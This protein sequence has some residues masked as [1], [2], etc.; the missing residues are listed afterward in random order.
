M[1]NRTKETKERIGNVIKTIK[2]LE[3]V[4]IIVLF[5]ANVASAGIPISDGFDYPV[6]IPDHTGYQISGWNFLDNEGPIY[7]NV[8]HPG[9][10]WNGNGGSD[11]DL[12]DSVYAISNGH[13]VASDD[14][15]CGWG[16]ITLIEHKLQNGTIVWSNYAHLETRLVSSG[17][18]VRRGEQIGT[19]GKGA[20]SDEPCVK[21]YPAHLHF[22]TRRNY[23][24]PSSWTP[25]VD[26][27]VQVRANYYNPSDFINANRPQIAPLVGD[28]D[29]NGIDET[30]T[31][32][33]RE[34]RFI[35]RDGKYKEILNKQMGDPGDLPIVGNWSGKNA[36]IGIYRPKE[37]KFFL[38]HNNDGIIDPVSDQEFLFGNIGDY[39]IVGDWDNDGKDEIGVYR[40]SEEDATKAT[41]FLNK[42][43]K[44]EEVKFDVTANDTPIIGD[45]NNDGTDDVGVFRRFDP[46]NSKNAVF[47]LKNGT[48]MI[49]I[50]FGDNTDF[51]LAG[52][53]KKDGLTR[54]GIYRPTTEK[55]EFRSKPVVPKSS[56]KPSLD[57]DYPSGGETWIPGS[58]EVIQW[59]AIGDVGTNLNIALLK[60]GVLIN[61]MTASISA[62]SA[63]II[64]SD[65]QAEGK[66][67]QIRITSF[68]K[69]EYSSISNHFA[70]NP[71]SS[72]TPTPTPTPTPPTPTGPV[73]NVNKNK[74]YAKIQDAINDANV[75]DEINVYSGTYFEI[76]N[77][78]KK[79]TI[80][81]MD[82]GSGMPTIDAQ[83]KGSVVKLYA[84][85][86]TFRNF[87]L[88]NASDW[89]AGIDVPSS[90]NRILY[91][92]IKNNSYGIN[93][94]YYSRDN[95]VTKNIISNGTTGIQLGYF[96]RNNTL[97][98]ND[99]TDNEYNIYL[100][101]T[102]KNIFDG[103]YIR[104]GHYGL[105]FF[106]GAD[107]STDNWIYRN[108]F[109]GNTN[110][111]E[112]L[113]PYPSANIWNSTTQIS[114]DFNGKTHQSYLG[115]YWDRYS[116]F[117]SDK[118]GIGDTPYAISDV[119]KEVD[120]YPL[121]SQN[122]G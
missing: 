23:L 71:A 106:Y 115:N 47:Y 34:T 80:E 62:N 42:T 110:D 82:S 48:E 120:S 20:T 67:Y 33:P 41:F 37:A 93:F 29:G 7:G 57:L 111:T 112:I 107:Y 78:S 118:D 94:E 97:L 116:G 16:N 19:I 121:M 99:I 70:I 72:S 18:Y 66:D 51:P 64:I 1:E 39:P 5:L 63:Q 4:G 8:I 114:Y 56:D 45:W 36:T 113:Y 89:S 61:E 28:W 53:P 9:E 59:T 38:D 91:N 30:G 43:D 12:G 98:Q 44:T 54:I 108:K 74:D 122:I 25:I 83:K 81:G 15:G 31:F 13:V 75:E 96:T 58:T 95:I 102:T 119:S 88:V 49:S 103:N 100:M 77:A 21:I 24:S 90:G 6:G 40:I 11:T 104:S 52:K 22:E 32:N 14:Y 105:Y 27:E 86:V 85:N 50:E 109:I 46:K 26:S 101:Y 79:L 35:L 76:I 117:D 3:T 68:E 69:P 92:V 65:T 84:G 55:F 10:D 73:H 2:S 60:K 17:D 87:T